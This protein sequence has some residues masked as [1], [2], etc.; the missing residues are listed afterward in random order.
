[1]EHLLRFIH[2]NLLWLLDTCLYTW[3]CKNKNQ[4]VHSTL[5]SIHIHIWCDLS[6]TTVDYSSTLTFFST[7]LIF[8]HSFAACFQVTAAGAAVICCWDETL[9]SVLLTLLLQGGHVCRDAVLTSISFNA[10]AAGWMSWQTRAALAA[11]RVQVQVVT[12]VRFSVALFL[13]ECSKKQLGVFFM[14]SLMYRDK[15]K[16]YLNCDCV[17]VLSPPVIYLHSPPTGV[18]VWGQA[19]GWD[20]GDGCCSGGA[21]GGGSETMS[22]CSKPA[23]WLRADHLAGS[24]ISFPEWDTKY[25]H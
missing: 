14:Y 12:D 1:M 24:Q 11:V 22:P 13:W 7:F 15:Y 20:K 6:C 9:L 23:S 8:D 18:G 19:G 5:H 4:S 16:I 10:R 2:K 21:A 17:L 3:K 25:I